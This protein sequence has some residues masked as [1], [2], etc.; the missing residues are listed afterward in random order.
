MPDIRGRPCLIKRGDIFHAKWRDPDG[1]QRM[2]SLR[3][4]NER[5]ARWA[6]REI[7]R[8]LEEGGPVHI[9]IQ[10]RPEGENSS[11]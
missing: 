9:V 1:R 2:R 4:S 7:E 11:V 10:D 8:V 3:T 6:L 5:E